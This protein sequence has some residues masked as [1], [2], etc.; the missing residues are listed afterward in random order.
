MEF[1][2]NIIE[3]PSAPDIFNERSE[4]SLIKQAL[5]LYN[6]PCIKRTAID[7]EAF[8]IALI[9]DIQQNM[10]L[11]QNHLPV[12][13][14]SGHGDAKGF[15]LSNKEILSWEEIKRLLIPI[16]NALDGALLLCMSSCEGFSAYSMAMA[17][18]DNKY[19][20]FALIGNVGEP[21]WADTAIAYA[22][23]Y[24]LIAKGEKI[25]NAVN[26]MKI[27]SGNQEFKS[28]TIL[29]IQQQQN[30]MDM[31]KNLNPEKARMDLQKSLPKIQRFKG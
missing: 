13:H 1:F 18:T 4:G 24:H 14:I 22:C 19:P 7:R 12:L 6:I 5:E 23:F 8:Q 31:L 16:N 25:L 3:S 21:T 29:E 2:V 10:S 28:I 17:P 26:A 20:F 15:Q 9:L 30:Y 11:F 27:A